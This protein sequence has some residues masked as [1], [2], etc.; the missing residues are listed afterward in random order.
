MCTNFFHHFFLFHVNKIRNDH[1]NQVSPRTIS[2]DNC[3]V[4]LANDNL[5]QTASGNRFDLAR[6]SIVRSDVGTGPGRAP[7]NALLSSVLVRVSYEGKDRSG[8]GRRLILPPCS[9][10]C[11]STRLPDGR[12][13]RLL[14]PADVAPSYPNLL[15]RARLLTPRARARSLLA[16]LPL[17]LFLPRPIRVATCP[18]ASFP[19]TG[20][21][22]V[23]PFSWPNHRESDE[24]INSSCLCDVRSSQH[25][26]R[27]SFRNALSICA[28]LIFDLYSI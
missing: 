12:C 6:R 13:S 16:P 20:P 25:P 14:H 17:P 3:L 7:L 21:R 5:N 19:F 10:G 9:P 26:A 2:L 1:Y 22:P 27:S 4:S 28:L 15:S 11:R 18:Y 23:R 24:E 8:P